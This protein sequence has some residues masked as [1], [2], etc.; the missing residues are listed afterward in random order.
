MKDHRRTAFLTILFMLVIT[1]QVFAA[2]YKVV[3]KDGNVTYTDK[4]PHPDAKPVNLPGLSIISPQKNENLKVR[5]AGEASMEAEDTEQV[6]SI[7]DLRRGYRDFHLVSPEQEESLRSTNNTATVAW[8]TRYQL[9]AGMNV[10]VYLDG[11][12]QAP[13]SSPVM[14]FQNLDRGEHKVM[15]ELYDRRNRKIATSETIT[16]YIQQASVQNPRRRVTGG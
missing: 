10:V 14:H 5:T 9:Q 15:A 16:F 12:A 11:V 7:R 6:E 2:V 4:A 13:T 1:P 8:D 3:D